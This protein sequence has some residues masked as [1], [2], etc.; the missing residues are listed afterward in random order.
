MITNR[1]LEGGR[2]P[3]V[4]GG[5]KF[6]AIDADSGFEEVALSREREAPSSWCLTARFSFLVGVSEHV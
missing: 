4:P 1:E 3:G 5:R 6:V 2:S